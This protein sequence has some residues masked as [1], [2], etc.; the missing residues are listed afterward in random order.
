MA[1]L[2]KSV[3]DAADRKTKPYFIWCSELPGFGVRIH[4][5][6]KHAYYIDYYNAAGRRKRMSMG[7]QGKLTA[8]EA[9]KMARIKLGGVLAGEDPAEER[10]TRRGLT[11]VAEV[12]DAY[13]VAAE[14]GLVLGRG[15]RP[16]K[17]ST[18]ATDRGRIARHIKPLLGK[19][20]VADLTTADINKFVRDVSAG[21][22]AAVVKTDNL[23]GK[24][25]VEG[26]PGAAARTAGLLGG[27]LSYAVSEGIIPINPARGVARPADGSK[28]RRLVEDEY[29]ALGKAL[30]ASDDVPWQVVAG[31][32]LLALTGCR[33]SE[34][35]NLRWSEVDT[36]NGALRLGDTKT[37]A[38]TR[39]LG[40]AAI[41]VLDALPREKDA[42]FVL[43]AVRV[44]DKPFAAI[45][46]GIRK[47]MKRAE[48]DGVTAH[49]L[50]HSFASVAADLN[51]SDSTIGACLGHAGA[52]ITSRYTHR[53]DAVLV[54]AA[55]DIAREVE[56]QLRL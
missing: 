38:S 18:L 25:I 37:G 32:K 5:S 33:K 3:I 56:R 7:G 12:C 4:P 20:A 36:A 27:I 55:N 23:R 43:P 11:T 21:K 15:R 45:E 35:V 16:K 44:D 28:N 49:T 46:A 24:A 54:A 13:L 41:N 2:T 31:I 48:L 8:D 22:T 40:N 14:G 10:K 19:K 47:V 1:K 52:G 30:A 39:P 29:A 34:I 51:Y 53:L 42:K 26:G 6:G 17:A 50:R 9:R